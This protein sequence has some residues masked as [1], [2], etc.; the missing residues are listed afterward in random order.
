[1]V[2]ESVIVIVIEF[3]A[4]CIIIVDSVQSIE[5]ESSG[6]GNDELMMRLVQEL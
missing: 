3:H 2:I 6:T 4:W 5:H 1:M